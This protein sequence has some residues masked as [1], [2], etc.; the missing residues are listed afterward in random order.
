MCNTKNWK[1]YT[2]TCFLYSYIDMNECSSRS[3]GILVITIQQGNIVRNIILSSKLFLVDLAGSEPGMLRM[4]YF[5]HPRMQMRMRI[6]TVS[7]PRMRMCPFFLHGIRSYYQPFSQMALA[8]RRFLC[9]TI[10]SGLR[11]I[12][13]CKIFT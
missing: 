2:C 8:M 5:S 6:F 13:G 7:N 4:Q 12:D 10:W 9:Q 11:I 1:F 3:H